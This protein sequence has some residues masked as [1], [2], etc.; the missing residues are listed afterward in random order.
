MNF[1][2]YCGMASAA[3]ILLILT[4]NGWLGLW[5]PVWNAVWKMQAGDALGVVVAVIGGNDQPW[6]FGL[7][8]RP[9]PN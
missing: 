3:A 2:R 1:D 7:F 4:L 9:A 8:R 5:G 6:R